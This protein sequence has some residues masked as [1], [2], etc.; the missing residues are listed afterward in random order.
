MTISR[1]NKIRTK[2]ILY[3]NVKY[4]AQ[5]GVDAG[6]LRR[7]F[8]N[9]LSTTL[10]NQLKVQKDIPAWSPDIDTPMKNLGSLLH[11]VLKNKPTKKP[12]PTGEVFHP[13]FFNRILIFTHEEIVHDFTEIPQERLFEILVGIP[14]ASP[15]LSQLTGDLQA[16]LNWDGSG[17]NTETGQKQ[18]QFIEGVDDNMGIILPKGTFSEEGIPDL[19]K[20]VQFKKNVRDEYI[21]MRIGP[22]HTMHSVAS[23][24]N[25]TAEEWNALRTAGAAQLRT[26]IQGKFEKELLKNAFDFSEEVPSEAREVILGWVDNKSEDELKRFLT[27]IY[28]TPVIPEKINVFSFASIEG[29]VVHNCSSQIDLPQTIEDMDEFKRGLVLLLDNYA[30]LEDTGFQFS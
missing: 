6:G 5:E 27:F 20:L 1:K 28:G 19:E 4:I 30:N 26:D 22:F 11:M 21:N 7:D 17:Y 16:F 18:R 23:G 13:D 29:P 9:K 24:F 8:I 3:I 2:H 15:V 10:A 25:C 12:F 14:D